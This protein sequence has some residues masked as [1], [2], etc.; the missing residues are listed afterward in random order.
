MTRSI[1][2]S[3]QNLID[4]TPDLVSLFL[5]RDTGASLSSAH[6]FDRDTPVPY[7]QTAQKLKRAAIT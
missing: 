7:A 1:I 4:S 5:Q 2:G 6:R 3:L